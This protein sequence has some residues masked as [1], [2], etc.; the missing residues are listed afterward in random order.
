MGGRARGASGLGGGQD[1][2]IAPL[3]GSGGGRDGDH[4]EEALGEKRGER[5]DGGRDK[6][7]EEVG[8]QANRRRGGEGREDEWD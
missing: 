5:R 6:A 8:K 1:S 3:T 2:I 4:R 7:E